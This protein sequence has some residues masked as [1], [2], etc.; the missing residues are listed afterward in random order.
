[1]ACK[2]AD[3]SSA[4]QRITWA[5]GSV[6]PARQNSV[7]RRAPSET[8]SQ[9]AIPQEW[10]NL[11]QAELAQCRRTSFEEGR[12]K[13]K[14]EAAAEIQASADRL[15]NTLRDLAHLKRRIRGEAESE[16]VKLSLAVAR[17]ILHRELSVDPESMQ[18]IVHAALQTLQNRDIS[19]IR[20]SPSTVEI[21]RT[22][23]EKAG[24][25]A[26]IALT[27][28]P[29]MRPSDLVFET[30]WGELDASVETQL[31]EIERGFSDR[32]G[33]S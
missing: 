19:R 1:M 15:A 22:A 27:P 6:A 4:I 33:L 20:V 16:V 14:E 17:R 26:S 28:D 21:T 3:D 32:L 29:S 12:K 8:E 9:P 31:L 2:I 23:L 7:I 24:A 10:E 25:R 11:R 30:S 5:S 13:G 18:G